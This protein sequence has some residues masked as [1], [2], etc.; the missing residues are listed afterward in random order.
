M[1]SSL[2]CWAFRAQSRHKSGMMAESKGRNLLQRLQENGF[3]TLEDLKLH[4][5]S[6]CLRRNAVLDEASSSINAQGIQAVTLDRGKAREFLTSLGIDVDDSHANGEMDAG[7]V[8]MPSKGLQ[9]EINA[10]MQAAKSLCLAASVDCSSLALSTGTADE[11]ALQELARQSV[12]ISPAL[13]EMR[14]WAVDKDFL[15]YIDKRSHAYAAPSSFMPN[16]STT[17]LVAV[18]RSDDALETLQPSGSIPSAHVRLTRRLRGKTSVKTLGTVSQAISCREEAE[19]SE[20]F[21]TRSVSDDKELEP[22]QRI[23]IRGLQA[24]LHL[25]GLVGV[26]ERLEET[27]GRWIVRLE[28][29]ELKSLKTANCFVEDRSRPCASPIADDV[30]SAN[31]R[32]R[33]INIRSTG[34]KNKDGR[35]HSKVSAA[36][37]KRSRCK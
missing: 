7:D 14:A 35:A 2:A 28:S 13:A 31:T 6:T 5:S 20:R 23:Q 3:N 10:F 12:Q 19:A 26:V 32:R 17:A 34:K 22:G 16:G 33:K 8:D 21:Q 24:S 29:G 11:D 36:A 9:S 27:S 18:D 4:L 15:S 37:S 30:Q 1:K 25:N